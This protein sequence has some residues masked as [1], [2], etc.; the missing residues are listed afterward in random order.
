VKALLKL[1][2]SPIRLLWTVIR[3]LWRHRKQAREI[4]EAIEEI[5]EESRSPESPRLET[6]RERKLRQKALRRNPSPSPRS[7]SERS[8]RR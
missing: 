4:A 3:F 7:T 5:L 8:R 6:S 2:S 1:L